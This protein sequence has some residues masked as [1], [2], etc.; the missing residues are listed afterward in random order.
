[1]FLLR[2]SPTDCNNPPPVIHSPV[3]ISS[4]SHSIPL[5]FRSSFFRPPITS[6]CNTIIAY[7]FRPTLFRDRWRPSS[8]SAH[9][10][11]FPPNYTRLPR[12]CPRHIGILRIF[13]PR[14]RHFMSLD[15]SFRTS[16]GQERISTS[17]RLMS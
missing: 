11:H 1:M 17:M 2:L 7:L 8:L 3:P 5:A 14:C 6:S 16:N 4:H 9:Q 15:S 13:N 10:R 12:P